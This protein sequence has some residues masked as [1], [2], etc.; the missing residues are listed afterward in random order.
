MREPGLLA[1]SPTGWIC[2]TYISYQLFCTGH[3]NILHSSIWFTYALHYGIPQSVNWMLRARRSSFY[4]RPWHEIV[5]SPQHRSGAK[6]VACLTIINIS[7]S[8]DRDRAWSFPL[9][10]LLM[11]LKF[12]GTL[13]LLT[14]YLVLR[15]QDIF[16]VHFI[17]H[18]FRLLKLFPLEAITRNICLVDCHLWICVPNKIIRNELIDFNKTDLRY[19]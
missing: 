6:S 17:T 9:T 3:V 13:Y 2:A 14:P 8:E 1:T 7:F 5:P 18:R 11:G 16:H 12:C 15:L 4:T 19:S 10:H